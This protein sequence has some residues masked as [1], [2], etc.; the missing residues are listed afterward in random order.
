MP[1]T[2][3]LSCMV[4]WVDQGS[5]CRALRPSSNTAVEEDGKIVFGK[6]YG[7]EWDDLIV[8]CTC[9]F[10]SFGSPRMIPRLIC[11]ICTNLY[12]LRYATIRFSLLYYSPHSPN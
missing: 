12:G 5:V 1:T 8:S 3:H 2:H 4:E 10:C 6:E 9:P 7:L 11:P